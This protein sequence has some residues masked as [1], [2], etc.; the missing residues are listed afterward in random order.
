MDKQQ[1]WVCRECQFELGNGHARICSYYVPTDWREEDW[2]AKYAKLVATLR[3]RLQNCQ[4][5]NGRSDCK[6]C[7]LCEEDFNPP[8]EGK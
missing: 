2:K 5:Q 6:N 7:G 1:K 4:E 8:L 3:D